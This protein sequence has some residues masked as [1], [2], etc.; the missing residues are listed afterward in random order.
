MNEFDLIIIGGSAT[1]TASGIYAS[2]RKV[3]FCILTE[4]W[5][6]EVANSGEIGNYPGFNQTDGLKLS[7]TFK[8]QLI[9]NQVDLR[10]GVK[11]ESIKKKVGIF[12]LKTNKGDYTAKT[13][14]LGTGV[15]PRL[16]NAE[17]EEKFRNKGVSYCS[18]CD[19]PLFRNKIVAI[20]GGG[21]SALESAIMLS[22]IAEKIFLLTIHEE[23]KG[24]TIY[25]EKINKDPKVTIITQADTRKFVGTNFLEGLEYLDKKTNKVKNLSVQ[26]AFIH[27]GV[28][29]NSDLAPKEV[30]K[31]NFGEIITNKLGE[32]SLEGFFSAG[33]VTDIPFKQIAIATGQATTAV[34]KAIQY[35]DKH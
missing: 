28:V 3:N 10:E 11:V 7:Q 16:L 26:G 23:L 6:G 21:N 9:F 20:I 13:I 24:E 31:N 25:I 35:L 19:G 1:A 29:P 17:N 33:D 34:L 15:H 8:E 32:T 5:G 18:T 12:N 30:E 22:K 14:L 27:I 2:R 4:S